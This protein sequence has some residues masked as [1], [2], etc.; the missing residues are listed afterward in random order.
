MDEPVR[1]DLLS[2]VMVLAGLLPAVAAIFLTQPQPAGAV[3]S[4]RPPQKKFVFSQYAVNLGEVR[5]TGMIPAHFDFFN[6]GETPVEITSFEPSCGCLA[7]KLYDG[8]MVYAPQE[9]GR[10]YVSVNTATETPG[11]KEYTVAIK[12]NDG[13]PKQEI[14][15]FRLTI[16]ERKVSV[17]PSEVYFYQLHGKADFREIIVEDHR[18]KNLNVLD[19]ECSTE[20]ADITLG[21]Q[22]SVDGVTRTPI[23]IDVPADPPSGRHTGLIQIYT[24]D[25]DFPMIPV[26]VLI[27]G[28]EQKIQ[29]VSSEENVKM[30]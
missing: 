25:P 27:Y 22:V 19:V 9:Q 1:S 11:P 3:I 5:P 4:G 17:V 18:G 30:Q 21:Q 10:F 16:P 7:P 14:V 24:D 28:P 26:P 6:L 13:Q 23:R 15:T 2:S 20:L 8:K 29:Q 12:F